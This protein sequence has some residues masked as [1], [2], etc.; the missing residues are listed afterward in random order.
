M[1]GQKIDQKC[2]A[3]SSLIS[4]NTISSA[5]QN[6]SAEAEQISFIA[7][8]FKGFHCLGKYKLGIDE[9]YAATRAI[10]IPIYDIPTSNNSIRLFPIS[11]DF[12]FKSLLRDIDSFL[13]KQKVFFEY[14][15]FQ[16]SWSCCY[17]DVTYH[18]F[19]PC[20]VKLELGKNEND[21]HFY[22]TFGSEGGSLQMFSKF[23]AEL[24]SIFKPDVPLRKTSCFA[25]F[26]MP[27]YYSPNSIVES[28]TP[29]DNNIII[30]ELITRYIDSFDSSPH[31]YVNFL[32]QIVHDEDCNYSSKLKI[33]DFFINYI[34]TESIFDET[35][36]V[37]IETPMVSCVR[38]FVSNEET[39]IVF[40][41][42][43]DYFWNKM[44]DVSG[45]YKEGYIRCDCA[46]IISEL[47]CSEFLMVSSVSYQTYDTFFRAFQST[48]GIESLN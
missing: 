21:N 10:S 38:S 4:L 17:L 40:T 1:I 23:K 11:S 13:E 44:K 3:E 27:V 37:L 43:L 6:I 28:T 26:P 2:L 48:V 39:H 24:M 45:T 8:K 18:L 22:L 5:S 20:F 12:E 29:I 35:S 32:A 33:F 46:C 9:S 36:R 19:S 42:N 31:E 15:P 34:N 25:P 16:A 41:E 14:N 7:T 30:D 47:F